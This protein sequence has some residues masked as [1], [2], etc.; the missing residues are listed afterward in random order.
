MTRPL[1][2]ALRALLRLTRHA[3]DPVTLCNDC[4]EHQISEELASLSWAQDLQQL[5]DGNAEKNSAPC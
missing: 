1:T 4:L 5:A 2:D 3:G